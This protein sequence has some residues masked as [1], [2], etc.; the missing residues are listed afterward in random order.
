MKK[1]I[2][3]IAMALCCACT[4]NTTKAKKKEFRNDIVLKTTPVKNQ[5][6]GTTCWAYAMLST[7]ETDRIMIGDS[8]NLSPLFVERC[9]LAERAKEQYLKGAKQNIS[10]RGMCGTAL[11][12]MEQ[13][14]AI[15]L[16]SYFADDSFNHV[17]IY[18]KVDA[19]TQNAIARRQGLNTLSADIDDMLNNQM[20][21]LP[22]AVH[23][24]GAE[25][26]FIEFAHSVYKPGSYE[27]ITSFTHH[28]Y[29]DSFALEVADNVDREAFLNLPIDSLM[30]R[31]DRS[32][33]NN[34]AVCWEGDT[35]EKGFSFENGIAE[36]DDAKHI[37]QMY[38]QKDFEQYRTTDDHAMSI[39][40]IA[41]DKKG[42]K[43][44]IAK[45]SWGKDNP[46]GGLIY[47]SEDYVRMKTIAVWMI[48]E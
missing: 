42:K 10:T 27:G 31:I 32:L 25:Y 3:V 6:N 9:M 19:I 45:N 16:D 34:H 37:S 15:P 22:K 30:A 47:M 14:G 35:S 20:G 24:L 40:G 21:F 17:A 41:H 13:Y 33:R 46:Y 2:A 23:M 4:T 38:R 26:T 44:Y 39:I 11:R 48:K 1:I 18:N 43:Y 28:P 29:Y 5:E 8:V 36:L 7:I 12:M